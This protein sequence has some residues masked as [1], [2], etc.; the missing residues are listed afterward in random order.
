MPI[1]YLYILSGFVVGFIV[2]MTGVG[3]GSLMTP[4]LVLGFGIKPIIAVG[5]D[6]LYAAI[7]KSGGVFVHHGHGNI[8]WD[9]VGLLA[10]GSVPATLI[11]IFILKKLDA[12]GVEYD[13]LIMSTL[14]IALILTAIFLLLKE[15][16]KR[17]S[18][19]EKFELIRVIHQQYYKH[20][21]ILSGRLIGVLVTLCSVGA[22]VIGAAG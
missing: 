20:I 15:P 21:T 12:S 17:V 14:S 18:K 13:H 10:T 11:T 8:R 5:T 4:I 7:T 19:N 22:G 6:L 9:I 2:G 3:G 16:L 1:E